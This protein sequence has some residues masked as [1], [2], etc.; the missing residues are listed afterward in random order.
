MTNLVTKITT[1]ATGNFLIRGVLDFVNAPEF[2]AEGCKLISSSTKNILV[3]DLQN[4]TSYDNTALAVLV[5]WMR[6]AKKAEKNIR[7]KLSP[8]LIDMVEVS[9]LLDILPIDH[10]R[11][12]HG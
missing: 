8:Q 11:K 5:E 2:R 3:F 10:Y 1:D 6:C 7:F 12:N 4:V 9:N